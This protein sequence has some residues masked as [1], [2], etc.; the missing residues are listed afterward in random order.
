[1]KKHE[2]KY[3]LVWEQCLSYNDKCRNKRIWEHGQFTGVE[4][5]AGSYR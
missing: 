1:M 4:N 5:V 2:K 3:F